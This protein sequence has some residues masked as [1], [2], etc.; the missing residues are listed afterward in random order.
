MLEMDGEVAVLGQGAAEIGQPLA[1]AAE[2]VGDDD[3]GRGG[4][5]RGLADEDGDVARASG[6]A[7]D[8]AGFGDAGLRRPYGGRGSRGAARSRQEG[9]QGGRR[10]QR[11]AIQRGA[12][13]RGMS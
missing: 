6:V 2:A 1:G 4:A 3:G 12:F 10:E 9:Q 8:G 11:P 5:A 13:Q 7:P